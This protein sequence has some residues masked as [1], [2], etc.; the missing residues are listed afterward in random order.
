MSD[1]IPPV[2]KEDFDSLSSAAAA[3]ALLAA[4]V[5][6]QV[7]NTHFKSWN[8]NRA[9]TIEFFEDDF[10]KLRWNTTNEQIEFF[11]KS[12]APINWGW[13]DR[14]AIKVDGSSTTGRFGGD[15]AGSADDVWYQLA[16][17]STNHAG[18]NWGAGGIFMLHKEDYAADMP[19]YRGMWT[20]GGTNVDI[21]IKINY[22]TAP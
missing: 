4:T 5:Q 17:D 10:I 13:I 9:T 16:V 15:D 14:I 12:T 22:K 3:T 21:D 19:S 6:A 2:S 18:E 11:P 8:F 1:Y 20:Y 7:G